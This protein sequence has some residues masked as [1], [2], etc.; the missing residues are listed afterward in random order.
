[1]GQ[2]FSQTQIGQSIF[3]EFPDELSLLG[4][5][6]S[7]S[8]NGSRI[9]ISDPWNPEVGEYAGHV[10]VFELQNQEWVQLGND[11]DASGPNAIG[12]T[13]MDLSGDGNVIAFGEHGAFPENARIFEW[14]GI[15]WIQKGNII[16]SL[17]MNLLEIT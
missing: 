3:K 2:L 7:I 13:G 12:G 10:R 14:D 17:F 1:L 15:D 5:N 6:V 4:S 11:I 9:A 16:E 8:A